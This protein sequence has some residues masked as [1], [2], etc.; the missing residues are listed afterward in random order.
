[1]TQSAITE[2]DALQA[3]LAVEH[4]VVYGYG[5]LG[6]RINRGPRRY[7]IASL[8]AHRVRRDSIESMILAAHATPTP[9]AAAY[10]TPTLRGE[11]DAAGFGA[12]LEDG[13]AGAAWDLVVASASSSKAR[14]FAVAWLSDAAIRG[15]HWRGTSVAD[16]PMPGQPA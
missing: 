16:P 15:A 3:A 11:H 6:A 4:Q 12:R 14:A 7:A 8:N 9:S 2:L 1:M 5:V 10:L 13:S